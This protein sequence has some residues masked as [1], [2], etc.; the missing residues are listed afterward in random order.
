MLI[1]DSTPLLV[2]SPYL[3]SSAH[4]RRTTITRLRYA[5]VGLAGVTAMAGT[6][7]ALGSVGW[8]L[9]R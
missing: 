5:V 4:R 7:S 6:I 2:I 3:R 9:L 1:G 8:I